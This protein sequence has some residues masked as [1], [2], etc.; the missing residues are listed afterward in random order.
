MTLETI[1]SIAQIILID[2]VLS[3]D[4]AVVIAM[5]AHKLPAYQRQ[6]AIL[7]GG[8]IAIFLRIIFTLVMAFL[9]MVPGVRMIGGLVLVWI[10]CKLLVEGEE[11]SISADD[12]DRSA[13]AAI[14]MIFVA[15]FVMSLD[16]MLAV[17][18]ASHGNWK[19]LLAGLLVSIAII[20]TCSAFIARLMSR[21][22]W[23][24]YL[25][26]AILAFTAGEM[27]MG[28][29]E[30]AGYIVRHHGVSF[31]SHW[32]EDYMLSHT[33]VKSFQGDDLPENLKDVA[34]FEHGKL[35]FIGQMNEAQRDSLLERVDGEK[36]KTAIADMYEQSYVRTVPDWVPESM[37]GTVSG[38]L[39]RKWPVEDFRRVEGHHHHYVAWV[40]YG[41]VIGI[42]LT[43]PYWLKRGH[44]EP[45]PA[46][47]AEGTPPASS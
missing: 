24:V 45:P 8:A 41:L 37:R 1:A 16:N 33:H 46:P 12:A 22:K 14:R 26:A 21:F 35:T 28:D 9:L 31:N 23:I 13:L 39:Q 27:M 29:R 44:D 34:T 7:W 15:D 19:L 11:H 5:A 38:W 47:E 18:G 36:D 32:L 10:A 40:V 25:G 6:R 43:A 17:A 42:C 4:N 3:G 2:I 30:L 20:M